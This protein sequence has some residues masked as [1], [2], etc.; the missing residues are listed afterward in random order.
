MNKIVKTNTKGEGNVTKQLTSGMCF[1]LLVR[2]VV[3]D[4]RVQRRH[5]VVLLARAQDE[6]IVGQ[7]GAIVDDD[8]LAAPVDGRELTGDEIDPAAQRD[9]R[10]RGRVVVERVGAHA[11]AQLVGLE[12][13]GQA[14]RG[15]E[16]QVVEAQVRTE[17]EALEKRDAHFGRAHHHDPQV[18]ADLN[19]YKNLHTFACFCFVGHGRS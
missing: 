10:V 6:V 4:A 3:V 12:R 18:D 9:G 11:L 5:V 1:D 15:H 14:V 2:V 13:V 19:K 17:R 7:D 16:R 8:V